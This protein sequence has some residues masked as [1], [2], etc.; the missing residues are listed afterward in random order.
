[1]LAISIK[2]P[3][4]STRIVLGVRLWKVGVLK[5]IAF[6]FLGVVEAGMIDQVTF[7]DP[8]RSENTNWGHFLR[9]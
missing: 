6:V 7:A 1:M 5:L 3:I 2:W 4:N 9:K 8:I